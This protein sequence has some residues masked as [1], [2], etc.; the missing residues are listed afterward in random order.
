MA[1]ISI[2]TRTMDRPQLLARTLDSLLAQTF[3]DWELVIVNGGT[4]QAYH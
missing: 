1:K 3:Q 2:I 4:E